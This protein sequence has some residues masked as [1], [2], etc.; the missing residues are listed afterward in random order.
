MKVGYVPVS[1]KNSSNFCLSI[2]VLF[3]SD[4][5]FLGDDF[6]FHF[7]FLI[8][9]KNKLSDVNKAYINISNR[10]KFELSVGNWI[11]LRVKCCRMVDSILYKNTISI[12]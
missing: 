3:T 10:Q 5:L 8:F 12:L 6:F 2:R 9:P 4:N 11:P 1:Y 7:H